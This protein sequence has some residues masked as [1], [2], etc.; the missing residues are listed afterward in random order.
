ML[1]EKLGL[2]Q[3][4]TVARNS[5]TRAYAGHN[6]EMR[7][8]FDI[9]KVNLTE[10]ARAFGL[11][12]QLYLVGQREKKEEESIKK[13][14]LD[15]KKDFKED[16][17]RHAKDKK[18]PQNVDVDELDQKFGEEVDLD[19]IIENNQKNFSRRLQK[20][21]IKDLQSKLR[22]GSGPKEEVNKIRE[23]LERAKKEVFTDERKIDQRKQ[24][25]TKARTNLKK[26]QLSEFL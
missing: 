6:H 14:G 20:S 25:F 3:L 10:F 13:K 26:T 22:Q 5:S 2:R 19:K 23:E 21:K 24:G 7:H 16:F 15:F 11:Y 17:K 18:E 4:G 12:K 8:I 9:R 1:D